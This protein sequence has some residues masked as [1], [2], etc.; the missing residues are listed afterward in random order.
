MGKHSNKK[1]HFKARVNRPP[2]KQRIIEMKPEE[3][4]VYIRRAEKEVLPIIKDM[5]M[6]AGA[7]VFLLAQY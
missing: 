4:A 3:L 6:S 5:E 7:A 2:I 1:K